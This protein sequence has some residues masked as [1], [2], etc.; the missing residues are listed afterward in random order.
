M[1]NGELLKFERIVDNVMSARSELFRQLFDPR[2]DIADECGYP[3][4]GDH[5]PPQKYQDLFDRGAVPARVVEVYPKECFQTQPHVYETEDDEKTEFEEAWV[6]LSRQLR[7][8]NSFYQ[9]EAGSPIWEYLLRA[10]ILSGI[11]SYGVI[12]LGVDDGKALVEPVD[13]AK[14]LTFLR[15][16]PE[17]YAQ[18]TQF[19]SDP[20]S[21]RYGLPIQY[22]LT[23]NDPKQQVLS[24]STRSVH[25]T[26]VVHIADNL[27]SNEVYGV[28]RMQPVLERLLDLAKLYSGSAEMYW[29]GAFPG[30][31]L[32]T[33]PQL[34]GDVDVD[35]TGIKDMMEQYT[36]GLQRYV[37]LMGMSMQGLAPQVV[38]PTSQINVQIEA[39]CIK[40]GIPKRIFIGSERGELA[41]SQDDAAWN[42]RLKERRKS[43]I[44]PKIIVP[45][46]DRLINLGILPEPKGYS[47]FWDDLTSMSEAEKVN[48]MQAKTN[49]LAQY[50]SGNVEALVP[51]KTYLVRILGMEA[52]EVDAILE[53][54]AK[55]AEEAQLEQPEEP[56]THGGEGSGGYDHAG[57]PGQVGGSAPGDAIRQYIADLHL[58]EEVLDVLAEYFPNDEAVQA[59]WPTR[60]PD[61][62]W[63]PVHME[64]SVKIAGVRD[65]ASTLRVD[66]KELNDFVDRFKD[67][68]SK[69]MSLEERAVNI[70]F[71]DW[72][73][74]TNGLV[75]QAFQ[76]SVA[77]VLDMAKTYGY[78]YEADEI[79]R[80]YQGVLDAIVKSVY[81]RTQEKIKD[82]PDEVTL[83]RGELI[84]EENE[85]L[86]ER[87]YSTPQTYGR[88]ISSYSFSYDTAQDFAGNLY[89]DVVLSS[90]IEARV[91]KKDIFSV[92]GVGFGCL[93]D[94]E[95]VVLGRTRRVRR[96]TGDE[97][98][99]P[100]KKEFLVYK[101]HIPLRNTLN[102][103]PQNLD[104][105]P[106]NADWL[107]GKDHSWDISW[108]KI[109][110]H[111]GEGSGG[112]G[113]AGRSGQVGG[114]SK[115]IT[116]IPV[117]YDSGKYDLLREDYTRHKET[118][119]FEVGVNDI[120]QRLRQMV[121][122][123]LVRQFIADYEVFSLI[124]ESQ[125][126]PDVY[127]VA[128][129][130]FNLAWMSME[131]SL[132]RRAVDVFNIREHSEVELGD[133]KHKETINALLRGY[134]DRTQ[135]KIKNWPDEVTLYRGLAFEK[136]IT[137]G[138]VNEH[139][140]LQP[141]SSFSTSY[142]VAKD[143][144]NDQ[145]GRTRITP[146]VIAVNVP[147]KQIFSAP[148][149]G[150][151]S[152][153]MA[154]VVVIGGVYN[155]RGY[156]GKDKIRLS[157]EEFWRGK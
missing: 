118:A 84:R 137:P 136:G 19:D 93:N 48:L 114:S 126:N 153:E 2:R 155:A 143:W 10:D 139:V 4:L 54:A 97:E 123:D 78:N 146:M 83:Y 100:S 110:T 151:G 140:L 31:V 99:M 141:L 129:S 66:A 18:I 22:L 89:E 92:P 5:I 29:R 116:F 148:G 91:L 76:R 122:E 86:H 64:V 103:E 28:P 73:S 41:S 68:T 128:T 108:V 16:F 77:R 62:P 147:K 52:K 27:N 156:V 71:R 113:H 43:Y 63:F 20:T 98:H 135:E 35:Q 119:D 130:L 8:E 79:A 37:A 111:G 45:F 11:G 42:D 26:R 72:A 142:E 109:V 58:S 49:A 56:V 60:Y 3:R 69:G 138:H 125:I 14:K 21:L 101:P 88:P 17:A 38:D 12:L 53:E 121:D 24:T 149:A 80:N 33:H 75:S 90:M 81:N 150:F 30:Y 65:V 107:A 9:D 6:Q 61:S 36:N 47:I 127:K 82:W 70:V 131:P 96:W 124:G 57:R 133:G 1:E 50:I 40:L 105:D 104:E 134:Y 34:G 39:I 102:E 117:P 55:A 23:F 152:L 154:E 120:S 87:G 67:P 44:T 112:Y 74:S 51:P 115:K 106:R 15:V 85:H 7:G 132:Q 59:Q 157:E 94:Q 46:V 144:A 13:K 95:V 25:W 145:T 32:S